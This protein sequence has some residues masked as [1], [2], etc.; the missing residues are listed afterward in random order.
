MV[1]GCPVLNVDRNP[2]TAYFSWRQNLARAIRDWGRNFRR[3][4]PQELV[5]YRCRRSG[6]VPWTGASAL[7]VNAKRRPPRRRALVLESDRAG[8]YVV[9]CTSSIRILKKKNKG[10][11]FHFRFQSISPGPQSFRRLIL[12]QVHSVI[13]VSIDRSF[14]YQICTWFVALV[15][16][17][18][19]LMPN[20]RYLTWCLKAVFRKLKFYKNRAHHCYAGRRSE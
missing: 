3:V 13:L 9:W 15:A 2:T 14:L 8:C 10:K 7:W 5:R 12:C 19:S 16:R 17:N 11:F 4:W 20:W 1:Q 6:T 18:L